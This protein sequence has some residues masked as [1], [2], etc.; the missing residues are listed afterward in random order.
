M[1]ALRLGLKKVTWYGLL[2]LVILVGFL[3]VL[4]AA[5]PQYFPTPM[6][7]GFRDLDC[8]GVTC[9]EGQFCAEGRRCLP[10]NLPYPDAVPTGNQ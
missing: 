2:A 1:A 9:P 5:A 8:A 6:Y 10:I 7:Q 4:K 3:P